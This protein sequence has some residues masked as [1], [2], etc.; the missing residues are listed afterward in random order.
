MTSVLI[1]AHGSKLHPIA[2]FLSKLDPV[3]ACFTLCLGAI[4]AAEKAV[5]VSKVKVIPT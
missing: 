4:A 5:I 2:Y 3:A 1:Q